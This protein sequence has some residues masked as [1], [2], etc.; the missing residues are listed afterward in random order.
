MDKY[1]G[2]CRYEVLDYL[3]H[4]CKTCWLNTGN[5]GGGICYSWVPKST[6]KAAPIPDPIPTP[7]TPPSVALKNTIITNLNVLYDRASDLT[8]L[9]YEDHTHIRIQLDRL[10]KLFHK[11]E[12]GQC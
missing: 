3:T 8:D 1:C 2:N 12:C 6:P 11:A 7:A 5:H 9:T 10:K 4:P